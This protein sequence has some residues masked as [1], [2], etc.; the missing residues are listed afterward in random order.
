MNRSWSASGWIGWIALPFLLMSLAPWATAEAGAVAESGD[1]DGC[2]TPKVYADLS[3]DDQQAIIATVARRRR[4]RVV[5]IGRAP[6]QV[7]DKLP[8]GVLDVGVLKK[9][10]CVD[11][12]LLGAGEIYWLK[13]RG[14][15]WV[16]VKRVRD[17][18]FAMIR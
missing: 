1:A 2:S 8:P 16:V 5:R 14:T 4:L 3:A 9:G 17:V 6:G 7:G 13:R 18:V 15:R 12:N 11:G 10:S